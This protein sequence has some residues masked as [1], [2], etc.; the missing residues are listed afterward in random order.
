MR[1]LNDLFDMRI[2]YSAFMF[3]IIEAI[4]F[5]LYNFHHDTWNFDHGLFIWSIILAIF[6]FVLYIILWILNFVIGSKGDAVLDSINYKR[7]WGFV[8]EG[9]H[10]SFLR[11][12]FQ[13]I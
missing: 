5:T 7:K 8:Y 9:L 3:F 11:R 10:R 6:Y 13:F 4:V 2:L 12:I 1:K